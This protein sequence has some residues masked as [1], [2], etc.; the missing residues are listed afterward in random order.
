[1]QKFGEIYADKCKFLASE[2]PTDIVILILNK[3][4]CF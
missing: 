1:M 3:Y 4:W 2:E